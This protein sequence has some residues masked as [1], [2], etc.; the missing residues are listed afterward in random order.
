MKGIGVLPVL[1]A[2][3]LL[4]LGGDWCEPAHTDALSTGGAKQ[5]SQEP[6]LALSPA[7]QYFGDVVLVSQDG[8]EMRLYSD[9]LRDKVVVINAFFTSCKGSCPLVMATF[10]SLQEWL[11]ERLGKQVHLLSVSVD[12]ETDTPAK[13]K[14]YAERLKAKPGWYFLTGERRHVERALYKLG[15]FVEHREDHSDLI[16]IGNETTGLWKKAFGLA[17]IED[18]IKLVESVLHD[19]G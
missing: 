3:S 7:H 18:I 4:L 17:R 5:P 16:I 10:A 1:C 12:P 13:L 11:G 2:L 15:Q 8:E 9:L 19:R 6:L 14:A